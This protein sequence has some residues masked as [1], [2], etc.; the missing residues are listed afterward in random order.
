[1]ILL[2]INFESD[3]DLDSMTQAEISLQIQDINT[4]LRA[5]MSPLLYSRLRRIENLSNHTRSRHL[6]SSG[7]SVG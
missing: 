6:E 2:T 5:T 4:Y 3:G 7:F 1:M